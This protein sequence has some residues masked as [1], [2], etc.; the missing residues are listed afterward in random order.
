MA[1]ASAGREA[2][3]PIYRNGQIVEERYFEKEKIERGL[4][5]YRDTY[6][7]VVNYKDIGKMK[8]QISHPIHQLSQYSI[9]ILSGRVPRQENFHFE[10]NYTESNFKC[11]TPP[12]YDPVKLRKKMQS[13]YCEDSRIRSKA[14]EIIC[15]ELL[16]R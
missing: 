16:L 13:D 12:D 7:Y 15:K 4:E 5:L 3:F 11:I 1:T 8:G 6:R 9:C 14:Q 10:P 2:F